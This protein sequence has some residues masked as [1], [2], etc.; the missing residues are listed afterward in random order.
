MAVKLKT[1]KEILVSALLVIAILLVY[2]Q[3]K[4]YPFVNYDDMAYVVDNPHI[5]SGINPQGIAW[6]FSSMY[7]SNW[8]P[9]TW[10]SHM[11]DFSLYGT[12]P[13]QHHM[14]NVL[15][16]IINTLLLFFLFRRIT[17]EVWK[18]AF[19]AAVFA[20]HPL[21]VESVAWIAERKDVLCAFFWFL[22]MWGYVGYVE[23]PS[24]YRYAL[25]F[26]F[27]FMGI[28]S[29]PMIVTLPF[30]LLLMDYWPLGRFSSGLQKSP[31]T[32][33]KTGSTYLILEKIPLFLLV[34]GAS[35][36][37]FIAQK[38]GGA[39]SDP[40]FL[41]LG[42]RIEN[43]L[44]S[45]VQ[46][47]G[48]AFWPQGL[49]A[50]YPHPLQVPFWKAL[51]AGLLLISISI[52]VLQSHRK[53]P[54]LAAGWLWYVGTLVPVIGLVQVGRQ[55][56]AD[57][58][59]YIPLIG[60]SIMVAWGIPEL[61]KR[62]RLCRA[63]LP[64]GS[65]LFLTFL[66][67][68]TWIQTGYWASSVRLF[69]RVIQVTKDNYIAHYNLANALLRDK[70][71]DK[72]IF[73]YSKAL[74]IKPEAKMYNN[75]GL[76]HFQKKDMVQA[77]RDY[78]M[79]LEMGEDAQDTYNN[80]GILMA[81]EGDLNRAI[82]FYLK[83]LEIKPSAEVRN[84]LGLALVRQGKIQEAIVSFQKALQEAP[85]Y[86]DPRKNLE[87][88]RAIKH[89]LD[90]A[91]HEMQKAL[92]ADP[93]QHPIAASLKTLVQTR[94]GLEEAIESYQRALSAQPGYRRRALKAKNYLPVAI[95]LKDYDQI[96]PLFQE[97]GRLSP[98]SPEAAHQT[99]RIHEAQREI[100][101]PTTR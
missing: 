18:S 25:V 87:R 82:R 7:L 49:C 64:V 22:T 29:K 100:R 79:A 27:L 15:F 8:Y 99:D 81:F 94:E 31:I 10:I 37:T 47:L 1:R 98:D 54:Y 75:R 80:L 68:A 33:C 63:V 26:L 95:T 17:Q 30:V 61:L 20:L 65:V 5:N 88:T 76:A 69:E 55:A 93:M 57:R 85:D 13:G 58:Y 16:H 6:S 62:R 50:L 41:S 2:W 78:L 36:I 74:E 38:A 67:Y 70:D 66:A 90:L 12:N 24:V 40:D 39:V 23:K 53:H 91:V 11:V 72:A 83:S 19:I 101:C 4:T 28:L 9:L 14:T 56:M 52:G 77:R 59:I 3:V 44:V 92:N 34:A 35:V 84:N 42:L 43:A 73:H 21:H 48:K 45:Y 32:P 51:S 46:Y 71:H 60:L 96:F 89:Q 97:L 86:P